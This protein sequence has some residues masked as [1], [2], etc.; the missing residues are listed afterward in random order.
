[1]TAAG[2]LYNPFDAAQRAD[3]YPALAAA[4]AHGAVMRLPRWQ[5]GQWLVTGYRDVRQLLASDALVAD[6][7]PGAIVAKAGAALDDSAERNV[8]RFVANVRSWLFFVDGPRHK[9]LRAIVQR[10]FTPANVASLRA[11]VRATATDL[12]EAAGHG[13]VDMMAQLARP[14]PNRVIGAM[15]GLPEGRA[16]QLLDQSRQLFRT[17]VPPQSLV[18]YAELNGVVVAL[19]EEFSELLASRRAIPRDDILSDLAAAD[20]PLGEVL[21]LALMLFSVGQDT[22]ENLIG[23]GLRALLEHDSEWRR[24]RAEPDLSGAAADEAARFDT[25]VQGVA[26]RCVASLMVGETEIVPGDRVILMLAA[27]NRDPDRFAEPDRFI[28][29]RPERSSLPFGGGAHFCL[30][31]HLAKLIAEEA[32]R[33]V[34]TSRRNLALGAAPPA[35]RNVIL[36]HALAALPVRIAPTDPSGMD[37][38]A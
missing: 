8:L 36:L 7:L 14:L 33:A 6:D 3:P 9:R 12:F 27:A 13:E 2:G 21:G 32:F 29:D 28:L 25:P 15:L 18:T 37:A 22:T 31:A 38:A 11:L 19:E 17:L 20:A 26:R 5:G 16:A 24:L 30:G 4:R 10:R 1:M 35:W 34:A 23:N